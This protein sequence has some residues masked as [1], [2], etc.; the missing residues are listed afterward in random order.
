MKIGEMKAQAISLMLPNVAVKLDESSDEEII[1]AIY[2]MKSDPNLESILESSVGAINR[3]LSYL[4]ASGLSMTKCVDVPSSSCERQ[5]DKAI[6]KL[7]D[8]FMWAERVLLHTNDV[9]YALGFEK[10]NGVITTEYMNGVYTVVYKPQITRITRTTS[11]AYDI[12]LPYGIAEFIP[13]YIVS[14]LAREENPEL[15]EYAYENFER[16]VNRIERQIAPCD[17]CFQLVYKWD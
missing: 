17:E 5:G 12:I 9:T 4:E 8:D 11:D 3:A 15:A 14:D 10:S 16:A 13:Y 6:I 2:E 7:E 1:R